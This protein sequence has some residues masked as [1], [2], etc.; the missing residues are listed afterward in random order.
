MWHTPV[1]GADLSRPR[2][3]SPGIPGRCYETTDEPQLAKT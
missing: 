3:Q 1:T 2:N